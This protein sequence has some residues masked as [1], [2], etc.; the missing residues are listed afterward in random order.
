[1]PHSRAILLWVQFDGTDF[2]GFQRQADGIRSVGGA[3][4]TAWLE[5][6]GESVVM[7]S[8]SRTDAG[9]HAERMP[10]LVRTDVQIPARGAILGL[11]AF[12]PPDVKVLTAEE[13]PTEFDVRSDAVGKRYVYRVYAGVVKPP[14]L[15]RTVWLVRGKLDVAAM[16]QGAA[17]WV[18][19]HDFR[20]FRSVHCSAQTT[21]RHMRA[22]D[23]DQV[24]E[25]VEITIDGNAFLHNMVRI[26]AGTLVGIG[27]H[28]F[29]P[30]LAAQLLASGDRTHGGQTAPALGLTLQ[31][32][33][34]GPS[35]ARQ[36]TDYK[37]MLANMTA[38]RAEA[39]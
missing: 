15:R 5:K 8:S 25:I 32:V 9:V 18:G 4:E 29:A 36:G 10:V 21:L 19:I 13:R 16:R 31:D 3:L 6:F 20:A 12:L 30:E 7:R 14:L 2:A 35:G 1:M 34:F 11:N 27:R 38:A 24:G 17:H 22:I 26:M 23:V 37:Q 39:T 33:F 28:R